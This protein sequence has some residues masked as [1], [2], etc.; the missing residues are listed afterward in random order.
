MHFISYARNMEDVLL[1]RALRDIATG[2]YIDVGAIH[3]RHD[4]A[5]AAFNE[6]GWHGINVARDTA[7]AALRAARP[8]D[9]NLPWNGAPDGIALAAICERHVNGDIHFLKLDAGGS[10]ACI[11]AGADFNRFRPWIVVVSAGAPN[12]S[13]PE[14]RDWEPA[15]LDAAY[16]FAQFDGLNYHYVAREHAATLR[17]VLRVPVNVFDNYISVKQL[18]LARAADASGLRLPGF[19]SPAKARELETRVLEQE[20]ELQLL[21]AEA[22]QAMAADGVVRRA[23]EPGADEPR[24]EP[25]IA[26]RPP[27]ARIFYDASLILHHG[28]LDAVGLVRVE[29]YLAEYLARDASVPLSFVTFDRAHGHYRD[30]TADERDLLER[31]LSLRVARIQA[32]AEPGVETCHTAPVDIGIA[33]ASPPVIARPVPFARRAA[34]RL[35]WSRLLAI[36]ALPVAEFEA[37][38]SLRAVRYFPIRPEQTAMRRVSTRV[39]RRVALAGARGG[40]RG[41]VAAAAL[42]RGLATSI[43]RLIRPDAQAAPLAESIAPPPAD[44][45]VIAPPRPDTGPAGASFRTGDV[46]ILAG[47]TWDYMDYRYLAGLVRDS[48]IR[49]IAVIYDV[50]AMELPFVTPAAANIYHRHWVEIGHCAE[51]LVAI[52]RFSAESYERFIARP[53]GLGVAI[54]HAPLPNF[55]RQRAAR[56][57]EKMVQELEQRNF[58]VYCSTIE[59]RKNHVLLL[60]LWDELR[61]RIAPDKLPVLVFVGKWGWSNETI[62][63]ISGGNW[64]LRP[65]LRIMTEISDAEL[66]WLYRNARFTVFPSLSEGFG[67]AAAESLSFGTPVVVSHCPALLEA[68][69]HLMPALHPHDF[70]GWLGEM[71]RLILDDAYLDMLRVA[72]VRFRGPDHDAFAMKIR[73]AARTS[74]A[75]CR[76]GPAATREPVA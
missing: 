27:V 38:I 5:T 52:S 61:Q 47:N 10:E 6:H 41:L 22:A 68:T 43:G 3:P 23:D 30:I 69:E 70:M 26:A 12:A 25:T 11:L 55:L 16:S 33:P 2:F 57:G 48:G 50:A 40:Y 18:E 49:F 51:R 35:H 45:P 56:I 71:E 9:V 62:R 73:D 53:N 64:R 59:L 29:H 7:I 58:V 13:G 67:L 17:P 36:G 20:T 60:H 37:A 74:A 46:L 19:A 32:P 15:L 44:T 24:A 75:E 8:D 34:R 76:T 21:R 54:D 72:A 28:L 14:T 66:I 1:W 39:A 31:I 63:L 4:S 65:H 42:Q